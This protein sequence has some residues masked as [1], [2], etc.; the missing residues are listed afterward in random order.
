MIKQG[1]LP[2]GATIAPII[3]SSNKTNLSHF[4]SDKQAWSVYLSVGNISKEI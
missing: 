2:E 1:L 4:S 3:L